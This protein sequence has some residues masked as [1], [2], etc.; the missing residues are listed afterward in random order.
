MQLTAQGK[1]AALGVDDGAVIKILEE[2]AHL[3]PI[4]TSVVTCTTT[5]FSERSGPREQ[6]Q[7]L[8]GTEA[9]Q[10]HLLLASMAGV[11]KSLQVP[12]VPTHMAAAGCVQTDWRVAIA[13]RDGAVHLAK[14]GVLA[15]HSVK[16]GVALVGVGWLAQGATGGREPRLVAVDASGCVL[17]LSAQLKRLW[18]VRI[19]GEEATCMCTV[20]DKPGAPPVGVLV[21]TRSGHM[22]TVVEGRCL[23]RDAV[24]AV[25]G[26]A[27]TT[28]ACGEFARE[29]NTVVAT[30]ESGALHAF[31]LRRAAKLSQTGPSSVAVPE[32]DASLAVPR[33]TRLFVDMAK[34]EREVGVDMHSVFQR[35]LLRMRLASARTFVRVTSFGQ[36]PT[37]VLGAGHRAQRVRLAVQVQGMGPRFVLRVQVHVAGKRDLAAAHICAAP[38]QPGALQCSPAVLALPVV[39]RGTS[40]EVTLHAL[41][42]ENALHEAADRQ[43]RLVLVHGDALPD[44]GRPSQ[45]TSPVA[46]TPLASAVVT[47]PALAEV[48]QRTG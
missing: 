48:G 31:V 39:V 43:L 44:T 42:M 21:G 20:S 46:S 40:V 13:T 9:G 32:Q 17:C 10:V 11:E 22:V 19:P 25:P 3:R 35:E 37:S 16:T 45:P 28:I 7:L 36:G 29:P 33:K 14:N 30:C 18:S 27:V 15:P 8:L 34:R 47:L 2:G 23:A 12:G 41:A 5:V 4:R 24:T 6:Q 1:L 38:T 26:D